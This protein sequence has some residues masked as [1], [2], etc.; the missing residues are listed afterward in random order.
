MSAVIA[1]AARAAQAAQI[2]LKQPGTPWKGQTCELWER[3]E[4][5]RPDTVFTGACMAAIACLCDCQLLSCSST[6]PFVGACTDIWFACTTT[7]L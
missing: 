6:R 5:R 2:Y 4:S 7:E 3:V 1:R